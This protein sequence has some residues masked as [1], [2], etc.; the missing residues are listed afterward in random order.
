MIY[1]ESVAHNRRRVIMIGWF[2]MGC[3]YSQCCYT[4]ISGILHKTC[5]K[6]IVTSIVPLKHLRS[7]LL[8]GGSDTICHSFQY[9]STCIASYY[10]VSQISLP[11]NGTDDA[12]TA[13]EL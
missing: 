5:M 3:H 10:I 4:C 1:M 11:L 2:A 9:V 12:C 8:V 13:V 7:T 6:K